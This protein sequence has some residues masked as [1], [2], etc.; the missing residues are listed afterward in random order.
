MKLHVIGPSGAGKSTLARE[1]GKRLGLPV[2]SLDP[3]A[4][5]DSHWTI[6]PLP[7]KVQAVREILRQ[8]GWVVDGDTLLD[9]ASPRRCR[10]HYLAGYPTGYD[11]GA[12]N[13][14]AKRPTADS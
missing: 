1:L 7:E 12:A 9:G 6:R 4:F 14:R 13:P 11:T 10:R 8:P 2:H 3:I 5:T